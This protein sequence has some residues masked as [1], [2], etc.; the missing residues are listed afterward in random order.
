MLQRCVMCLHW[1]DELQLSDELL[2]PRCSP[3]KASPRRH[4][5]VRTCVAAALRTLADYIDPGP[6]A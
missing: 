2:C 4:S 3:P 5:V 6:R 1:C